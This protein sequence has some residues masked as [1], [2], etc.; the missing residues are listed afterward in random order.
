MY[1]LVCC[2]SW[3]LIL[4]R[5]RVSCLQYKC[6]CMLCI[7]CDTCMCDTTHAL[8]GVLYFADTYSRQ[9]SC[10]M[11]AIHVCVTS[12]MRI[13]FSGLDM[14]WLRFVGSL[15]LQVSFAKEPYKRDDIL[16]KKPI[17]LRSLLIA[18]TAYPFQ[19]LIFVHV[20]VRVCACV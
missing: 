3:I 16:Q 18:A 9:A 13:S 12:L 6:V 14:G 4:G 5:P 10:L 1:L 19:D 7:V 15:N 2:I 11:C 8:V 20:F 17:I